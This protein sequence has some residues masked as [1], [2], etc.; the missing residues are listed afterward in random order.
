MRLV[1]QSPAVWK[2]YGDKELQMYGSVSQAVLPGHR[3][4]MEDY[5]A[6]MIDLG[7]RLNRLLA[8]AIGL[9]AEAFDRHFDWPRAGFR[10]LHYAAVASD[11]TAGQYGAGA[12][13]LPAFRCCV[14]IETCVFKAHNLCVSRAEK[15]VEL[16]R[17]Q[18]V[19]STLTME[20]L[21][22]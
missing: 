11:E 17:D 7:N 14:K 22:Y 6:A 18:C 12:V 4:V 21:R 15:G 10:L 8:L 9:P 2:H 5:L 1:S 20:I 13:S 16:T 3:K 19:C